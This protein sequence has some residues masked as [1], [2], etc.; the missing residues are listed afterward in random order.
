MTDFVQLVKDRRSANYFLPNQPITEA[1]LKE[2]YELLKLAP[3]AFNLQHAHYVS[4]INPEVKEKLKEAAYGQYKVQSASAVILVLGDKKAYHNAAKINEGLH[5]LGIVSKQEYDQIVNNTVASY[6]SRGEKFQRDEAIRNA[7]LSAML[8]MLA[9]KEKGW[10]TC[11][12]IGFDSEAVRDILAIEDRYEVVLM[13]TIGK[14][15]VGSRN[16]RGYRKPVS[17][18]VSYI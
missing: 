12:M 5:M 3:S 4:V 7:S 10:D 2:I 11:P 13:I 8:F 9:A 15:D 14:E 1:D 16:P 17:E 6:E 18:F